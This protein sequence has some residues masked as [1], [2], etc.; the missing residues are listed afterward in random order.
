MRLEIKINYVI[1]FIYFT[2]LLFTSFATQFN[3]MGVSYCLFYG[4]GSGLLRQ[5][6]AVILSKYFKRRRV[7]VDMIIALSVQL[8][9]AFF[10][11]LL[12]FAI[13]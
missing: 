8:G 5:S 7:L 9:I 2:G 1:I 12:S 13:K 11:I 6:S 10:P 4:L 3:Q